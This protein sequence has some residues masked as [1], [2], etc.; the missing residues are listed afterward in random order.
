MAR[1]KRAYSLGVDWYLP[2]KKRHFATSTMATRDL[3]QAYG[4]DG[5]TVAGTHAAILYDREGKEILQAYID[6]GYGDRLLADVLA[7]R[8]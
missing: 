6:A 3:I 1:R 5:F 7:C 4:E 8:V 2:N